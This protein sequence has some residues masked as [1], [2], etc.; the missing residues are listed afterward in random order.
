M[1]KLDAYLSQHKIELDDLFLEQK[2]YKWLVTIKPSFQIYKR[3]I[4]DP[5]PTNE[6]YTSLKNN[7]QQWF[8]KDKFLSVLRS[9]IK[10]YFSS[11]YQLTYSRAKLIENIQNMIDL[12]FKRLFQH[13]LWVASEFPLRPSVNPFE[14]KVKG[15]EMRVYLKRDKQS[16]AEEIG[17]IGVSE[18]GHTCTNQRLS[19][20]GLFN[21]LHKAVSKIAHSHAEY[22]WFQK[23]LDVLMQKLKQLHHQ[24]SLGIHKEQQIEHDEHMFYHLDTYPRLEFVLSS[25]NC[26]DCRPLFPELR[27]LLNINGIHIP[28]LIF[29]SKPFNTAQI[30][31]S[32]LCLVNYQGLYIDTGLRIDMD[33]D[34]NCSRVGNQNHFQLDKIKAIEADL[35][36]ERA[37]VRQ[38]F[39]I[40]DNP[41]KQLL[42]GLIH[43]VCKKEKSTLHDLYWLEA[44]I[45]S[46]PLGFYSSFDKE[47]EILK[48]YILE[49]VKCASKTTR[50]RKQESHQDESEVIKLSKD[51]KKLGIFC[52][53]CGANLDE[54]KLTRLRQTWMKNMMDID[55]LTFIIFYLIFMHL[56]IDLGLD[57]LKKTVFFK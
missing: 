9:E 37:L 17:E 48:N 23:F 49:Q 50:R 57:T 10:R 27:H 26:H 30:S 54:E 4:V 52:Q 5:L 19:T 14:K 28:L 7:Y 55:S 12:H 36:F 25:S 6:K 8:E 3:Y 32:S 38:Y 39:M 56:K 41:K 43:M 51:E 2:I 31:Q 15:V 44:W 29:S 22:K 13:A 40:T 53:P 18:V 45:N 16:V 24:Q 11:F 21:P 42:A 46:L 33:Y 35:V 20:E 1:L 34:N 47:N